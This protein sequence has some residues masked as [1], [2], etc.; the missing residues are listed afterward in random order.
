MCEYCSKENTAESLRGDDGIY[1]DNKKEKH[2][3]YIEHFRNEKYFIEVN[4]CPQCG[5]KLS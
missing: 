1:Y 5:E 3:L 2:Y 4:F